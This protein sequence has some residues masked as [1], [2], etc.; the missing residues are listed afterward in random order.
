MLEVIGSLA[1]RVAGIERIQHEGDRLSRRS[2]FVIIVCSAAASAILLALFVG[3]GVLLGTLLFGWTA[4]QS[5]FVSIGVLI[6]LSLLLGLIERV[7]DWW[8]GERWNRIKIAA[9]IMLPIL[10]GTLW[11]AY[12]DYIPALLISLA[13][14]ALL[15]T[16]GHAQYKYSVFK[17]WREDRRRRAISKQDC[18]P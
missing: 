8:T 13:A 7:S 3:V 17:R 16:V 6:A 9:W 14:F 18:S 12:Q 1:R 2:L 4:S 15:W 11:L 10:F 5:A